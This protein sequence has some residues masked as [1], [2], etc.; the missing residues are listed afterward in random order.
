[1]SSCN[2][3]NKNDCNHQSRLLRGNILSDFG[4]IKEDKETLTYD[5]VEFLVFNLPALNTIVNGLVNYIFAS[6]IVIKNNSG[7]IVETD[8]LKELNV[9]DVQNIEII[10]S[11]VYE[12]LVHGGVGV[13]VVNNS[14]VMVPKKQYDIIL[15]EDEGN[16][17]V[18]LQK[19][20]LIKK[21]KSVNRKIRYV[22]KDSEL[23]DNRFS[24]DE[25]GNIISES[26]NWLVLTDDEF[27]NVTFD[28][29][30]TGL[31]P[32]EYD[33]KR[34]H[35][36]LIVLDYFIHDFQR[37]GIGTLAFRYNESLISRL[38]GTGLPSTSSQIFDS[39][40]TNVNNNEEQRDKDIENLTKELS[41]VTFNESIIYSDVFS[42]LKQLMR[43]SKPSDFL[44]LLTS[45]SVNFMSQIYN[46]SPQVFDFESSGNV[47]K[48]EVI[49]T[50]IK[51]TVIPLRKKVQNIM[52]RIIKKIGDESWSC[53]FA[54][55][56]LVQY[57][58]YDDDEKVLSIYKQLVELGFEDMAKKYLDDNLLK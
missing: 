9:F 23:V 58:N 40:I 45:Y 2:Q 36:V 32:L 26:K 56:E 38:E 10:K 8:I 44:D 48:S 18:Y 57:Y 55:E 3:C 4:E 37:N 35:L 33:R 52:T 17:F 19:I 50:F 28:G 51:H 20:F 7:D 16:P 29:T 31:S 24:I 13:R 54:N 22:D 1:M 53:E 39:S 46:V 30:V 6:D 11:I 34:T 43:D 25:N 42:E 21:E 5:Q 12:L 41:K 15:R 27:L 47:G 14:L 49:E